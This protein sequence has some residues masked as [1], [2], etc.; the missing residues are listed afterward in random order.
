MDAYQYLDVKLDVNTDPRSALQMFWGKHTHKSDMIESPRKERRPLTWGST[1][2]DQ[3][4]KHLFDLF[5]DSTVNW[6]EQRRIDFYC[7]TTEETAWQFNADYS[8]MVISQSWL[9]TN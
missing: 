7:D 4:L 2:K 8:N 9:Y 1:E 3:P 6:T 5:T